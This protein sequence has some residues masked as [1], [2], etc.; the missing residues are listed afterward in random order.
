MP[1]RR[2]RD[3]VSH[4]PVSRGRARHA[5]RA[6]SRHAELAMR[7]AA[8]FL[9]LCFSATSAGVLAWAISTR[10]LHTD[11]Y[12]F[13][14][15]NLEHRL[16]IWVALFVGLCTWF[17]AT[18]AYSTRRPLQD[19]IRQVVNAMLVMLMIDGFVQ[20]AG[21]EQFSRLWIMTVWPVAAVTIPVFR[22]LVRRLLNRFGIWGVG[23]AV[24]G[25]GSHYASVA[26][27]LDLDQYVGYVIAYHS[28]P[29]VPEEM[30]LQLLAA[31]LAADMRLRGAEMAILVPSPTEMPCID[32]IIDA[33][34]LNLV[35][36]ILI[37][38]V[39]RL[40][41]AG[42]TVQT[43]INSDAILMTS[44]TG[45]MSPVRQAV[46]RSF[47]VAVCVAMLILLSPVL[48]LIA[49]LVAS[50]GGPVLFGH[51]RVGRNAVNFR[52]LKFR[53]MAVNS[54]QLLAELLARDPEAAREWHQNFKLAQDPRI[55]RFGR[56]L[57]KTSLDEL[58]QLINV[59][60]GDMSLVGPRPV[61]AEEL[62]YY[63]GENAFYYQ[64]VRP[65]ITGL[66]QVNGRSQTSYEHRVF[67]DNCYVRNWSL[68]ADLAIL[69]NTVP[70][71]LAGSGAC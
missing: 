69:F 22:V 23:A 7:A 65:G 27:F 43:M 6:D 20:F 18:G 4:H 24:I 1:P 2:S 8:D 33:L 45:L 51:K 53:T 58:P 36:F 19:D 41:F 59:L 17:G 28:K 12:A 60:R 61:V 47:D 64:L 68:W 40:P 63:Y 52:C 29:S 35:P 15:G 13:A 67:L 25:S 32:R 5:A 70:S 48:L 14:A 55:T 21:K 62:D 26:Q 16:G 3:G 34:N 30:P 42:L 38:P 46:K 11:Y 31:K 66:W 10:L 49:G 44:R 50:S 54:E 56:F 71:V 37:P 57:R 39:Q 9:A